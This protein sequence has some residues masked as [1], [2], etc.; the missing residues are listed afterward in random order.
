MEIISPPAGLFYLA[1]DE[2]PVG[3]DDLPA[4]FTQDKDP[5][6]VP[7]GAGGDPASGVEHRRAEIVA[8]HG[9]AAQQHHLRVDELGAVKMD[10]PHKLLHEW[11]IGLEADDGP[12]LSGV[13][14]ANLAGGKLEETHGI[15]VGPALHGAFSNSRI[16]GFKFIPGLWL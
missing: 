16:V 9:S 6:V 14:V 1:V 4:R 2:G 3:V 5:G 7:G 8:E 10:L 11:A 12:G 13:N 15:A